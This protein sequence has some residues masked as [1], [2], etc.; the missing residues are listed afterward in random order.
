MPHLTNS[1]SSPTTVPLYHSAIVKAK[2]E[3]GLRR[4]GITAEGKTN[5]QQQTL[6]LYCA[7]ESPKILNT[8][9]EE[10]KCAQIHRLISRVGHRSL[11]NTPTLHSK[12]TLLLSYHEET[13]IKD[14]LV[15]MCTCYS[16]FPED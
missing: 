12:S 3:Q 6:N 8:T 7:L 13:Q 4:R 15:E 10:I 2:P 11:I 9:K 16:C 14:T 1:M 5:W